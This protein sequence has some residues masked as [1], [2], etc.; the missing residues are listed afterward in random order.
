MSPCVSQPPKRPRTASGRLP[1]PRPRSGAS[2]S[3]TRIEIIRPTLG[4]LCS[5]LRC[6]FRPPRPSLQL[7]CPLL[8]SERASRRLAAPVASP[9]AHNQISPGIAHP[10]SRLCLSDLRCIVP[11]KYRASTISAV[12]PQC[13]AS[14]ASCT[15]GQRFAIRLPSDSQSPAKPLPSA[16]SSPC[17]ASTGLPPASRCA[18]PGAPKKLVDRPKVPSPPSVN[19]AEQEVTRFVI[20]GKKGE[21]FAE[22]LRSLSWL[23]STPTTLLWSP[24]TI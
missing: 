13:N 20:L 15:S 11:D 14:S 23:L 16:N 6:R 7:L 24:R 19:G 9:P 2:A 8:T 10:L 21:S 22:S 12:C 17:R 1:R 4:I 18:L 5:G 3:T